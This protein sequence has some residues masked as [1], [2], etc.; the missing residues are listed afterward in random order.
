MSRCLVFLEERAIIKHNDNES[1]HKIE[2]QKNLIEK[3][4]KQIDFL[5]SNCWSTEYRGF[6]LVFFSLQFHKGNFRLPRALYLQTNKNS[7]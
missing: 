1:Q 7:G 3:L 4:R 2:V 6:F 5:K